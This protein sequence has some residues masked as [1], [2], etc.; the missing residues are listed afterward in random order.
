MSIVMEKDE[1]HKMID[2]MPPNDTWDDLAKYG[3]SE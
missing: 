1:A 3:L 2:R